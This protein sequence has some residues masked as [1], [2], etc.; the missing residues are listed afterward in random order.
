MS[1]LRVLMI[2]QKVDLDDDILGFTHTWVNRLAEQVAYLHVL[3]LSVGRHQL[4]DNVTL[5]SMGKEQGAG[6]LRRFVNF[7]RIVAPL[8]LQRQVDVVFA[9]MCPRYAILAAS[10]AK[11]MRVPM[12]MWYAHKSVNC[13]L[14]IAHNLVDRV[15][16]ST[17]EGFRLK[18]DKG[19]IVGQGID[20]DRFKPLDVRRDG[21]TKVILS[22][23]RLSPIK[24]YETL[25][26]AAN[27]L[28][29][30]KGREGLEFV[31][32]GDVGTE[33]QRKY[34]NRIKG[35]VRQCQLERHFGLVGSVPHSKIVRYYQSCDVF[36]NLSPT[37][38]LD[39][40]V[41]E[42]MACGKI[43]LVCNGS[44]KEVFGDH[45]DRL[46]FEEG[47]ALD[48]ARKVLDVVEMKADSRLVLEKVLR[49]TVLQKHSVDRLISKLVAVFQGL[50]RV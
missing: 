16:T 40:A 23:G 15:V 37:G 24:G 49:G 19:S 10:Y 30:R 4:R 28:V 32:I 38:A 39:K 29:N 25:I 27:V 31:I 46:V 20:T 26:E 36:V 43:P 22:V 17:E 8:V 1:D 45:A 9:H 42:A 6:R 3:A 34:F 11:L 21:N 7:T 35:M 44:F 47:N 48:L 12:V 5:Y 13:E 2:T 18:S 50:M 41:L 33:A 14:R